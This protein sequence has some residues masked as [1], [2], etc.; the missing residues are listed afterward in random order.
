MYRCACFLCGVIWSTALK[1]VCSRIRNIH[2]G[3]YQFPMVVDHCQRRHLLFQSSV[4]FNRCDLK[5]NKQ[6][7]EITACSCHDWLLRRQYDYPHRIK[8]SSLMIRLAPQ[9]TIAFRTYPPESCRSISRSRRRSN[10]VANSGVYLS[11]SEGFF[12][13]FTS[14]GFKRSI[15]FS[16]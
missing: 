9:S 1:A 10:Q 6:P 5:V 7:N 8:T 3:L 15:S 16:L 2:L 4:V 14:V 13:S 11:Y 12:T